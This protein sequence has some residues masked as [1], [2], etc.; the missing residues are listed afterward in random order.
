[1]VN[2]PPSSQPMP[3]S[4]KCGHV[5]AEHLLTN[6]DVRVWL[7]Q[8]KTMHCPKCG[9]G[10]R[11]LSLGGVLPQDQQTIA[12]ATRATSDAE[13]AAIW[14]RSYD[15]GLSSKCIADV[16]CANTPSGDYPHDGADFGRC[17]RLLSLYP[18]WRARLGKM[19]GVN[20]YWAALVARWDEIVVAYTDDLAQKNPRDGIKC[21]TL[22]RE[23][24]G[25]VEAQDNRIIKMGGGFTLRVGP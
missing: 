5:F 18:T 4:C 11:K 24:L 14:L 10:Y 9:G 3:I 21:Y 16:M 1:M 17:H 20:V 23:I 25:G 7:A 2:T 13:R 15:T 12:A 19:A 8:I 6:V 22:M